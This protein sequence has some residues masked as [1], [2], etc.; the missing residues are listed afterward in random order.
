MLY[1]PYT[2]MC[3]YV[4][5]YL[6]VHVCVYIMLPDCVNTRSGHAARPSGVD[7]AKKRDGVQNACRTH[8]RRPRNSG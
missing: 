3:V 8:G 6:Y 1:L 2:C 7:K 4:H 5:M